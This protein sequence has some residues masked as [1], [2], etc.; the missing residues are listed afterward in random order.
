MDIFITATEVDKIYF[1]LRKYKK[2]I[3][4]IKS[5]TLKPLLSGKNTESA[6]SRR[7][8]GVMKKKLT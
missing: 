4:K 6:I 1:V 7:R 3:L 8:V 5:Q 2:M